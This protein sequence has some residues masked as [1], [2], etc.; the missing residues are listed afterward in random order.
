[1]VTD[2]A[3]CRE[4]RHLP[5]SIKAHPTNRNL[6]VERCLRCGVLIERSRWT[7]QDFEVPSTGRSQFLGIAE[8]VR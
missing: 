8:R 6:T 7:G 5:R 4:L 1:M 2:R 3:F